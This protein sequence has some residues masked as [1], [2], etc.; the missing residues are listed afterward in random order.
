MLNEEETPLS[1]VKTWSEKILSAVKNL[2][3]GKKW[4]DQERTTG[5]ISELKG[6]RLDARSRGGI[7]AWLGRRG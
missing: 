6:P 2:G 4:E 3:G 5:A 7:K 1:S